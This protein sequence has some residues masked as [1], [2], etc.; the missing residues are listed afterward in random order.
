[1]RTVLVIFIFLAPYNLSSAQ[2][3]GFPFGKVTYRELE[4]TTYDK[5]TSAFAVVLNETGE[6]YIE[7]SNNYNLIFKHHLKIKILKKGGLKYGD[8]EI[9]LRKN[10]GNSELL[11][12]VTASTFNVENGPMQEVKLNPKSVFTEN[13]S[14]YR[15]IKK[16]ALPNVRVGSVIDIEYVLESPF[17]RNFRTWEFQSDIP[18]INSEF[19]ASIPANYKYNVLLRGF[20]KLS[21]NESIVVK[22]C[23]TGGGAGRADCSLSQF[24]MKDIPAFLEE[25]YMTAKSNFLSAI[26]FELSE[27]DYFDGRKD[28]LTI[29]WKD[30]EEELRRDNKFGLQLKRGGDIVDQKIEQLLAGET[31]PLRKAQK[32]YNFIKEWYRWNEVYGEYSEFGIKKAFESKVGNVGDINLSLIAALKY[33]DLNVEPLLLSTRENGSVTELHPVLSDFNYVIAKLNINDRV[34]L[35]DATEDFLS[36][37]LIPER[38]LNGKGRVLGDKV[39]SWYELKAPER[40]KLI[41]VQKLKLENDGIMRGTISNSYFGYEAMRQRKKL[42]GYS[43]QKEFIDRLSGGWNGASVTK[44]TVE[45]ADDLTKPMIVNLEIEIDM[46]KGVDN[47]LLNP[48]FIDRWEGNPFKSS[49]RLYPVDFGAPLEEIIVFNLEYP[50]TFE[51]DELPENLG[52]SLPDAGGRYIFKIQKSANTVTMNSSLLINKTVFGSNE[53]FY[54]KELFNRVV[55]TQQTDLVFK[56]KL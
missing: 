40:Q 21:K 6:A 26:T 25:D 18:K 45:N 20:L 56:K 48:F 27:I 44:Y 53:Y 28:K 5:D 37:G 34:Y 24:A 49:E 12:M 55:S 23:F 47:F 32:I 14:K 46:Y 3:S 30:A 31:D 35:L 42:Y 29:E 9:P 33:A 2:T 16:F 54:L 8:F 15:D 51:I 43:N 7:N 38:C 19:S 22:E 17:I 41:S 11:R 50:D 13:R 1:M 4:M 39:S 10:E 52:L 36:F